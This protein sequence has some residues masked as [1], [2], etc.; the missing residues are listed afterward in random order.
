M[1][2]FLGN[3]LTIGDNVVFIEKRNGGAKLTLGIVTKIDSGIAY[4]KIKYSD[5]SESEW[6]WGSRSKSIY[7]ISSGI[8]ISDNS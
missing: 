2:D 4:I 1:K 6:P 5:G 8:S 3:E 7:K